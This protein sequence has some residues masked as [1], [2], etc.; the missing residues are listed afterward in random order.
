MKCFV[1]DSNTNNENNT[2][3]K[4]HQKLQD[5]LPELYPLLS[6]YL[7]CPKSPNPL[8]HFYIYSILQQQ[9]D[10]LQAR[11]WQ[12]QTIFTKTKYWKYCVVGQNKQ[13]NDIVLD[14]QIQISL[15]RAS[16]EKI[17]YEYLAIS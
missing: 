14:F 16:V 7:E 6:L 17:Q 12:V 11:V 5:T 8:F 10:F 4:K 1:T 13:F 2:Q 3:E 9:F 15:P